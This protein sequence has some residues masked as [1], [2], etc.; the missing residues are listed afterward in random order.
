MK[1]RT[2]LLVR[3]S[4]VVMQLIIK[5]KKISIPLLLGMLLLVAGVSVGVFLMRSSTSFLPRATPEFA[6]KN[7]TVTTITENSFTIS[8]VSEQKGVGYI[9]YGEAAATLDETATDDRDSLTGG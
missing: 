6:P 2:L 4:G 1:L 3:F 8:W 5:P 9:Q 7:L